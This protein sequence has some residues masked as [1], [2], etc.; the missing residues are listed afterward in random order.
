MP[1][2]KHRKKHK[3]KVNQYKEKVRIKRDFPFGRKLFVD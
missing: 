1:K 3:K 2:S